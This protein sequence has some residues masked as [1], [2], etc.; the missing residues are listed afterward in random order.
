MQVTAD[1]ADFI[2]RAYCLRED[3]PIDAEGSRRLTISFDSFKKRA[4]RIDRYSISYGNAGQPE[5]YIVSVKKPSFFYE[6]QDFRPDFC[7]AKP[8]IYRRFGLTTGVILIISARY[9]AAGSRPV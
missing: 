4:R 6:W 3:R 9:E 1:Q 2:E 8:A 7:R 5:I